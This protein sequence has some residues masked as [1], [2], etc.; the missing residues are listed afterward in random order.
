VFQKMIPDIFSCNM[1]KYSLI[2]V[3][4]GRN[5][6]ERLGNQK[7][8]YFPPYLNIVRILLLPGETQ[9]TENASF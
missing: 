7:L 3:I 8:V 2:F 5:V 9:A 1:S 4:F 6:T